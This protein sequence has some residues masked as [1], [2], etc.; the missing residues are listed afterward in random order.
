MQPGSLLSCYYT[1]DD[2]GIDEK[3]YYVDFLN[4]KYPF[5]EFVGKWIAYI[6]GKR[7]GTN[8]Y[9]TRNDIYDT[10]DEF[11][12]ELA[13]I[14]RGYLVQVGYERDPIFIISFSS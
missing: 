8:T 3:Q 7:W 2:V 6:N 14:K 12:K 5:D 13:I 10:D 11:V 1:K 9:K 4:K